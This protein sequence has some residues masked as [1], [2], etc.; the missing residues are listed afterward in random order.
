MKSV[1]R[2]R[3]AD[4]P[5]Q[6]DRGTS[7]G[8]LRPRARGPSGLIEGILSGSRSE[9]S[10]SAEALLERLA[11]FLGRA[12]NGGDRRR[13]KANSALFEADNLNYD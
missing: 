2:T 12:L 3:A 13:A 8:A 4:S 1:E 5:A 10:L 11:D 9:P 7:T 6:R